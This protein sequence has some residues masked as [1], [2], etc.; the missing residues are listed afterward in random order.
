MAENIAEIICILDR[1]GSM[2]N[3]VGET[4]AGYNTFIK[5]QI[6]EGPGRV[7][8]VLFDDKY[9]MVYEDTPLAKVPPLTREVYYD[10]GWTALRDG[11]GKTINHVRERH[12][13]DKPDKTI[14]FITTDGLENASTEFTQEQI[15]EMVNECEKEGW[16]FFFLGAGIDAFSAGTGMGIAGANIASTDPSKKGTAA[17]YAAASHFTSSARSDDEDDASL[18]DLYDNEEED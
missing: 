6:K 16:I 9:D 4:I 7:T 17:A 15:R 14:V 12:L 18:Q 13:T 11:I 3:L 10:R 2:Q 1:S 5:E 8:L